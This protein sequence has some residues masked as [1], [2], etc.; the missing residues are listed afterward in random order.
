MSGTEKSDNSN[1]QEPEKVEAELVEDNDEKA[2]QHS[3]PIEGETIIEP[4]DTPSTLGLFSPGVILLSL[5]AITAI[6]LFLMK[7]TSDTT[8]TQSPS[9]ISTDA[10]ESVDPL[11]QIGT[12]SAQ[13]TTTIY[14]QQKIENTLD[15]NE[16][17]KTIIEK[18]ESERE[19]ADSISQQKQ[20]PT[21]RA[22][23]DD[24]LSRINRGTAQ[25]ERLEENTATDSAPAQETTETAEERANRRRA[26][27]IEEARRRKL[28]REAKK[29]EQRAQADSAPQQEETRQAAEAS[30]PPAQYGQTLPPDNVI[31]NAQEAT[32][33]ETN[34]PLAEN[35]Q[36][37]A[38]AKSE[39][40]EMRQ[41]NAAQ[42]QAISEIK[43]ELDDL[44][45]QKEAPN[46]DIIASVQQS[47]EKIVELEERLNKL[48]NTELAAASKQAT[49]SIALANLQQ[50]IYNGRPYTDQL[51]LLE[52]L[53]PSIKD[54][55][56]LRPYAEDG[57]ASMT[58]LSENYPEFARKA[59]AAE[60][61]ANAKGG[62]ARVGA[63]LSNLFSVR[64]IGM[65]E[66]DTTSAI[67][68]RAETYLE[69]DD[70]AGAL[71]ELISLEGVAAQAMAPW[72]EQAR[73][74]LTAENLLD[75][76][77]TSIL[78]NED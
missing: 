48:Q 74:R 9:A 28:A 55:N 20:S 6:I 67:T 19:Q 16:D 73:A 40:E 33:Q 21:S 10:S 23:N 51:D 46:I 42:E 17:A 45:A 8:E 58:W 44:R 64:P 34:Q 61:R 26:E 1:D 24:A 52:E 54:Y 35:Q 53:A 43:R 62:L 72:M 12:Q 47:E 4:A 37:L 77:A 7:G 68:A 18:L 66:G 25:E 71:R 38:Q 76:I 41:R 27:I 70:L 49:T 63:N 57:L 69:A 13:S 15:E 75:S 32:S 11:D 30:T 2:R 59:L 31:D 14:P 56:K 36:A 22:D 39:L 50:K 78:R 29:A 60:N 65:V 5:L 3:D